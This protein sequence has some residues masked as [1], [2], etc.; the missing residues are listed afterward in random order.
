MVCA[1]QTMPVVAPDASPQTLQRLFHLG[2]AVQR[3]VAPLLLLGHHL[4]R[5][6]IHKIDVF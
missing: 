6:A 4:F 3:L 5:R 1:E 2:A